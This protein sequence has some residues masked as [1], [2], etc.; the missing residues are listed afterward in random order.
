MVVFGNLAV[1]HAGRTKAFYKLTNDAKAI[2]KMNERMSSGES[3]FM[4]IGAQMS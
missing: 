3:F 2:I 1:Q 4:E